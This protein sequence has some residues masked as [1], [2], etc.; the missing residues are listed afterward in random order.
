MLTQIS[1]QST[2]LR[3]GRYAPQQQ[4]YLDQLSEA[5]RRAARQMSDAVWSIDSRYDS[6]ASLL[7]RLRDH[8]HDVLPPAN[9]ELDFRT[10]ASI[11]TATLPLASR[12]AQSHQADIPEA[13]SQF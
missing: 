13:G 10:D 3:E 11:V 1:M 4:A 8:A 9:V 6:A 2:L 5:S 12:Q 7:D